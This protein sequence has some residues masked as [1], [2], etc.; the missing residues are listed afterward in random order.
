[1]LQ[2]VLKALCNGPALERSTDR[3][4]EEKINRLKFAVFLSDQRLPPRPAEFALFRLASKVIRDCRSSDVRKV[5]RSSALL[6]FWFNK[7]DAALSPVVK[8]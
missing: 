2:N 7:V 5:N 6:R 1:M 3:G 4:R 8:A